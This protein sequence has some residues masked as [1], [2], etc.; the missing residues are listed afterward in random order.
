MLYI[1]YKDYEPVNLARITFIRTPGN[2]TINFVDACDDPDGG[3]VVVIYLGSLKV[4]RKEILSMK[5]YS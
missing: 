1:K 5:K 2:H 4:R 3:M